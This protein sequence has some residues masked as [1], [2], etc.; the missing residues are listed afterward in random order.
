M[1]ILYKV[2]GIFWEKLV[3]FFWGKFYKDIFWG[4]NL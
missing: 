3:A 4:G 2:C 1:N